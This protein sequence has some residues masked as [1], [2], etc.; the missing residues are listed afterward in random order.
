MHEGIKDSQLLVAP[1]G[2]HVAPVE[3]PDVINSAIEKFL[4]AHGFWDSQA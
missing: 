1:G 3:L 4:K 2:T